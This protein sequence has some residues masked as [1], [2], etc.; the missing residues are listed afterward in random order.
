MI[1]FSALRLNMP[2]MGMLISTFNVY[3]TVVLAPLAFSKDEP[4]MAL[5]RV[6][7]MSFQLTACGFHSYAKT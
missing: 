5:S 2:I 1:V 7:S 3:V 6:P 4:S